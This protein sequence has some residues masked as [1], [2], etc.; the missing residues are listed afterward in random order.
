MLNISNA[1]TG[2]IMMFATA[3]AVSTSS[4]QE[5]ALES[6]QFAQDALTTDLAQLGAATDADSMLRAPDC[7]Y[8]DGTPIICNEP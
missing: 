5:D 8:P 3:R 4:L 6:M 7:L 2:V 1:L